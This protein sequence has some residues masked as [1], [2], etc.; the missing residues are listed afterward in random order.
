MGGPYDEA[1]KAYEKADYLS[2]TGS[3]EHPVRVV[4]YCL[5]GREEENKAIAEEIL[6]R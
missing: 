6:M 1:I 2:P 5:L 4:P 3:Y